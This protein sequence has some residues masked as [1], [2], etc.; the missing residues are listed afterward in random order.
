L[1]DKTEVPERPRRILVWVRLHVKPV[2]GDIVSVMLTVP[3][4]PFRLET[5]M[6]EFPLTPAFTI[7]AVVPAVTVK[8]WTV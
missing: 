5:V 6:V 4:K 2:G 3:L 1:Q 8:S 7:S